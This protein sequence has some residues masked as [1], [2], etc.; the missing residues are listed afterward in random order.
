MASRLHGQRLGNVAN[1][2]RSTRA[3]LRRETPA[4]LES[5]AHFG[6][7]RDESGAYSTSRRASPRTRGAI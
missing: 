2:S 1:A 5:Q 4:L 6:R 7:T 3:A